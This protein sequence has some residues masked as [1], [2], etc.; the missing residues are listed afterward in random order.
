MKRHVPQV[1]NLLVNIGPV[2]TTAATAKIPCYYFTDK[3]KCVQTADNLSEWFVL[4]LSLF[5]CE[6]GRQYFVKQGLGRQGQGQGQ[7]LTSLAHKHS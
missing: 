2:Q 3:I 6:T 5:C 4:A 7:G 1:Q